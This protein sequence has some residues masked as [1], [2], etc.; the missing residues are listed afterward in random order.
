MTLI[1]TEIGAEK[2][3]KYPGINVLRNM[4]DLYEENGWSRVVALWAEVLLE[5]P[6][7]HTHARFETW[8]L[9]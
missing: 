1:G 6:T 7:P 3:F 5:L 9:F 8:F 4:R 2:I